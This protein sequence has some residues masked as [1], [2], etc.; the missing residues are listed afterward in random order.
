[1][2]FSETEIKFSNDTD[3]SDREEEIPLYKV[4]LHNDDYTTMDFVVEILLE[5]FKKSEDE[6]VS[7]MLHVH[8]NGYGICGLYPHEIAETKVSAVHRRAK[9]AGFPLLATVEPA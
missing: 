2:P 1:M 4:V 9:E 3:V 6:A 8:H 7:I 5:I